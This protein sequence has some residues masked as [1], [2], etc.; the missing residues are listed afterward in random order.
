[1]SNHQADMQAREAARRF[2]IRQKRWSTYHVS[3]FL[4]VQFHRNIQLPVFSILP[5]FNRLKTETDFKSRNYLHLLT[6]LNV[7]SNKQ[8]GSLRKEL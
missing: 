8:L 7:R 5:E 3:F 1:M 4:G 6:K 2:T